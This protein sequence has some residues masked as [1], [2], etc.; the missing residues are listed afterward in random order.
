MNRAGAMKQDNLKSVHEVQVA[1]LSLKLRSS[2]DAKTVS[3]LI[4]FVEQK[5]N[6]AMKINSSASFQN[7]LVLASLNIAEE[8][9]LLKKNAVLELDKV[10]H[11]TQA[12]LDQLEETASPTL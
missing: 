3:E 12:I 11:R 1:G 6:E 9:L 5:I 7:A 2:H 4:N 8:L 10:E